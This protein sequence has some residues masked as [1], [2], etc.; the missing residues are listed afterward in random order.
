M[1]GLIQQNNFEK[2]SLYPPLMTAFHGKPRDIKPFVSSLA[3]VSV[4]ASTAATSLR[5][6][7]KKGPL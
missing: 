6:S 2:L 5:S 1:K 4:R 3:Q 7:I